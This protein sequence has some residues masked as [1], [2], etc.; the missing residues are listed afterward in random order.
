MNIHAG[1]WLIYG[2]V[3]FFAL[4]FGALSLVDGY[5]GRKS[6]TEVGKEDRTN[7]ARMLLAAPVWP[8]VLAGLIAFYVPYG[9]YRLARLAL[10]KED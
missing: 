10:N 8:L 6:H 2:F 5:T 7:G 9:I 3:A 1:Y 4:L